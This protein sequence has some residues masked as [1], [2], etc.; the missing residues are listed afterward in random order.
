LTDRLNEET[1]RLAPKSR[2][3]FK[4]RTAKPTDDDAASKAASEAVRGIPILTD[5]TS[6]IQEEPDS[7]GE[8]PSFPK[9]KNYNEEISRP[10]GAIRKPSFSAAREVNISGHTGLHIMLPSTAARATSSGSLTDLQ[11]CCVDMS[12]PT[13]GSAAF[14]SLALKNISKSLIVAGHVNGPAHITGVRGSI[15]VVAARQV[16]IHECE[17]VDVYLQ[18]GSRPIIEDCKAMRFAPLPSCYVS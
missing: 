8:M 11:G 7:V 10:G 1:A 18:C 2:F 15:I 6:A 9:T 14:L 3:Q 5:Q 12:V 17:N 16:R 13:A 4:P